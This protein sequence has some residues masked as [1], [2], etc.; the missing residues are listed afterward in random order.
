MGFLGGSGVVVASVSSTDCILDEKYTYTLTAVDI[1][2]FLINN[3]NR[4]FQIKNTIKQVVIL[5]VLRTMHDL[6]CFE[7][8]ET[9]EKNPII[10]TTNEISF[11]YQMITFF[12]CKRTT[13]IHSILLYR[14]YKT[15]EKRN[16]SKH[17]ESGVLVVLIQIA[18]KMNENKGLVASSKAIRTFISYNITVDSLMQ[19]ELYVLSVLNWDVAYTQTLNQIEESLVGI[20]E[21][22]IIE[23][24]NKEI[25]AIL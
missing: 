22:Q 12:G 6:L 3:G 10:K 15:L 8:M 5:H 19:L 14:R 4:L 18:S 16:I 7:N 1:L 24:I 9:F 20:K 25:D 2:F 11:L 21:E 17:I 23:S 13:L